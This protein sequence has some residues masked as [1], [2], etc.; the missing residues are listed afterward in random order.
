MT[1]NSSRWE[2]RALIWT[3]TSAEK[4]LYLASET[5]RL[6]NFLSSLELFS[7]RARGHVQQHLPV[8]L[9]R[10]VAHGSPKPTGD[11]ILILKGKRAP[12]LQLDSQR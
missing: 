11:I 8:R 1:M 2:I 7:R 4:L 10:R 6:A 3:N 5:A 12:E 9:M